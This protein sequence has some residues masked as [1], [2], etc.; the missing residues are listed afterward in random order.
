[1]SMSRITRGQ[2]MT[3]VAVAAASP[4]S[5]A[6]PTTGA[7]VAASPMSGAALANMAQEGLA[8]PAAGVR[9]APSGAARHF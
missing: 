1:M 3:S 6:A 9:V 7:R 4:A 2:G 5:G 8:A